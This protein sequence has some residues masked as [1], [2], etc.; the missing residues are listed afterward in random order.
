MRS[1]KALSLIMFF[2]LLIAC[3]ERE[4]S[5]SAE[6]R[7][8]VIGTGSVS[9][10]YYPTG[11]AISKIVNKK[12]HIYN[13]S[14]KAE[15]TSGSV[16]NVNAI[17][18]GTLEF[19]IVQS[20]RQAQ[21][22]QGEAEWSDKGP[23]EKL[24]SVFSIHSESVTLVAAVDADI[25]SVGELVGKRINIGNPGSGQR[26]NAIDVLNNAGINWEED[27]ESYGM[28]QTEAVKM[29]LE[30][31]IDALFYTVGHPS[32]TFKELTGGRREV[33]FIAIDDA[34]DLIDR[35]SYY[36]VS[37]IPVSFYPKALNEK[38]VPTFGVKAT[39]CTT[40]D[41]SDDIVYALTREIFENFEEF[42]ALHPSFSLLTRERMLE[43]LTAPIHEGALKYYKEAGLK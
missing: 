32:G 6:I 41:I 16:A 38:D 8:F 5:T 7:Y 26:G 24:R 20:D 37:E 15:S 11:G 3:A 28:K 19:G 42:K 31:R 40:E 10:V 36:T 27:I 29:L 17:M 13:L 1:A 4:K 23:Q 25:D 30:D 14:L 34:G 12:S 39:L 22:W 18:D 2:V 9:G 33:K 21:A 35:F 43:G